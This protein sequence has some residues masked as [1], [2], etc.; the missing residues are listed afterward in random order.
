[1]IKYRE[2]LTL[3]SEVVVFI[4]QQYSSDPSSLCTKNGM[5]GAIFQ[6]GQILSNDR[7]RK[8]V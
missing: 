2:V 4:Y 6:F 1:M 7:K 3:L 8:F 5:T